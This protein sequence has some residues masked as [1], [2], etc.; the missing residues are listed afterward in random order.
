M[1]TGCKEHIA[2]SRRAAG[3]GMV[4]LKNENNILPLKQSAKVALFGVGSIDYTK[5]GGGSGDVYC[6]WVHN[7]YDGMEEKQAQGKV[8]VFAPLGEFYRNYVRDYAPI[9]KKHLEEQVDAVMKRYEAMPDVQ[10]ELA[11]KEDLFLEDVTGVFT[12]HGVT[13]TDTELLRGQDIVR[14]NVNCL[15]PQPEIPEELFRQAVDFADTAIVTISRYSSENCDRLAEPGDYYLSEDESKLVEKVKHAFANCIVV[16]NTCAI[17]DCEWFAEDK[18][19][20][21]ALLAW[22][23][24]QEG[25]S[26]MADLLCGDVTPSG[27]LADT[28]TKAYADYPSS[29]TLDEDEFYVNY[30]EDIYVG[31]RY[32]ETIPGKQACV[33]YPFGYG[34]SYTDFS[35]TKISAAEADGRITIEA[36]VT[37]TGNYP[38]REVLQLYYAAPQGKL[39]KPHKALAAYQKTKCLQPGESQQIT[40]C[41]SV[42]DL[43]SYDDLGKISK[44]AYVLE[45]GEYVMYLGTSVAQ[46][47]AVFTYAVSRDTVVKQL[48]ARCVPEKL[49]KRLLADGTYEMLPMNQV[50]QTYPIPAAVPELSDLTDEEL[51][52]FLG[53]APAEGVCN[54]CCFPPLEKRGFAAMPTA[55]GP[56]GIRLEEKYA[57]PTTAWPSATLLACTWDP[58]LVEEIGACGG[59]E[60]KENGLLIWLTPA[61]NIHRTPL[62]GRNFE[63]FSEDPYISGTMAAAQVRGMQR[64]GMACSIKHFACNN[65]ELHRT[66]ND[67]RVSE[68]ALREIYL[69]GFEICVKLADPWTVMSSYN[70]L[71]GVH[72]SEN[73]DLLTAILRDEWG[74][75]GMVTTD[76]G[77]KYDPVREVMAGNDMKMPSGYPGELYLALKEGRLSRSHMEVCAKRILKVYQNLTM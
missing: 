63:Y 12:A 67:S 10:E 24:G 37:N 42:A 38:G 34:L 39:G 43:A 9:H 23:A 73:Y 45:Q 50:Q 27:K 64:S 57:I 56:A 25:G 54:T 20:G 13:W 48:S 31:Y 15:L 32:F 35:V 33:R 61:L 40:L 75:G 14:I 77:M 41:V 7:L 58:D 6:A 68:R 69:K 44:S 52:Q 30:Y 11:K 29:P 53:G 36:C 19:I 17:M 60:G 5:G 65:R 74:F 18:N 62:C 4:L 59:A 51:C 49:P 47:Q 16:L 26:A 55:D 8:E 2:L 76:W 66:K 1:I 3:E 28:I 70:P 72:T 21:G 71:N 46:T 22:Q